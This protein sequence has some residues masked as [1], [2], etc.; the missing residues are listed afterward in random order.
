MLQSAGTVASNAERPR[1]KGE[2]T[3]ERILDAAESLFAERGY[4]ATTLR[5]VASAV[6]IRNPSL[7][8][9][10]SSKESLYAAVLERGI[11]PVLDML[12]AEVERGSASSGRIVADVMSVLAE[13][14]NLPRLVQHET[15]TGGQ[16][17]TPML[18]DWIVPVFASGSRAAASQGEW[19]EDQI[20]LLVLAMYNVVVGYFGAASVLGELFDDDLLSDGA[21]ERQTEFL[22]E[23][24]T[25]LFPERAQAGAA[26]KAQGD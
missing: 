14:P 25:R 13:H 3:A 26:P 24:V 7:Y 9:H 16:H 2:I 17:L 18:R 10:F 19:R 20:P 1:R 15:L 8:N 6:G 4:G 11:R 22:V 23:F 5:D 21:L 12:A